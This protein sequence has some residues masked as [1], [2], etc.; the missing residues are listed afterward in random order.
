MAIYSFRKK[1]SINL[2]CS[3]AQNDFKLF[4]IKRK[5]NTKVFF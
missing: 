3:K 5:E 4:L 2:Y 1:K